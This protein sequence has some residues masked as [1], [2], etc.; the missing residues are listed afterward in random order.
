VRV[1]LVSLDPKESTIICSM[2]I[3]SVALA[4]LVSKCVVNACNGLSNNV[5][6]DSMFDC[7]CRGLSK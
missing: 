6:D 2:V 5:C 1:L 4:H 7:H 3:L